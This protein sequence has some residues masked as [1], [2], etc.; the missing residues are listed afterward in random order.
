MKIASIIARYLLISRVFLSAKPSVQKAK[1]FA[2]VPSTDQP[3][4]VS[5]EIRDTNDF[6]DS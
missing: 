6:G 1:P 5:D 3:M 2:L 4:S